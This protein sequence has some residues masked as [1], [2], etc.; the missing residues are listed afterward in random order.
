MKRI[1]VTS[2]VAGM[3]AFALT[4]QAQTAPSW[5]IQT[6]DEQPTKSQAYGMSDD[7]KNMMTRHGE[8]VARGQTSS[9]E[10][11]PYIPVP[12]RAKQR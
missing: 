12:I 2:S 3:M 8:D 6:R 1:I 9:G 11:K 10:N 5:D 4:A 7:C